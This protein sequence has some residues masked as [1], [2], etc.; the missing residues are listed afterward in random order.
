M[1]SAG[2]IVAIFVKTPG[3]S[4]VKTRLASDLGA[5]GAEAIYRRSLRCVT[6]AVD[7]SGL[8]RCWAV[9]E[10]G[11]C[12]RSP[13]TDAPC[14]AQPDGDLGTRMADVYR[15]LRASH[16]A[17]LLLGADLPQ[18]DPG[19]L[20]RA[21]AWLAKPDRHVMGPAAD[22]GFWLYGSSAADPAARWAGLPYSRPETAGRFRAAIAA[23][24][25]AW[26]ELPRR[27]DLDERADIPRVI[28]ELDA[29]ASPM[30][31]QQSMRSTLAQMFEDEER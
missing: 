6:E 15:K 26:L 11:A 20:Q 1:T 5:G 25:A 14:I 19:L 22:G 13:W 24:D 17:V 28:E 21:S 30:P 18:L 29:L 16:P 8:A 7:A 2:A 10:A 9:A 3:R 23:P 27:T 4:P 31:S 12:D